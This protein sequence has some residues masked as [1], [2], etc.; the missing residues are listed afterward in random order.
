MQI[1]LSAKRVK[2]VLQA[3][4]SAWW[5]AEREEA[6][7]LLEDELASA[8]AWQPAQA[9]WGGPDEDDMGASA[10]SGPRCAACAPA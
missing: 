3:W 2:S 5:D 6:L 9:L 10:A 7:R 4:R 1:S 8:A